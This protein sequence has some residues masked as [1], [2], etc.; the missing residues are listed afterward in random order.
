M[1]NLAY[2]TSMKICLFRVTI[3]SFHPSPNGPINKHAVTG[4]KRDR[5]HAFMLLA[6]SAGWSKGRGRGRRRPAKRLKGLGEHVIAVVSIRCTLLH[7][8]REC[9]IVHLN[10]VP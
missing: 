1:S 6:S 10:F 8:L 5:C 7:P 9:V 2:T 4:V 3:S